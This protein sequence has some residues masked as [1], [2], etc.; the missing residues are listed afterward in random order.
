MR[1]LLFLYKPSDQIQDPLKA[2]MTLSELNY[3][4]KDSISRDDYV[5]RF[6]V[7]INIEGVLFD[8]IK[9]SYEDDS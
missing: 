4:G 3:N 7:N 1:L 5:V 9:S 8:L 2:S 6:W